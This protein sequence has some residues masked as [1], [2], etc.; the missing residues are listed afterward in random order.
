MVGRFPFAAILSS[1]RSAIDIIVEYP[2]LDISRHERL[3]EIIQKESLELEH[4]I[5][6]KAGETFRQSGKLWPL[7]PVSTANLLETFKK[8]A[9]EQGVNLLGIIPVDEA[10][11]KSD[12]A[13]KSVVDLPDESQAVK[14]L[15][16]LM[17]HIIPTTKA[18]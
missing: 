1:I 5:Q 6:R 11:Y 15:N 9:E 17:K 16:D 10:I 3:T 12:L 2:E 18:N 7:V 14:V 13:G 8:K 4:L